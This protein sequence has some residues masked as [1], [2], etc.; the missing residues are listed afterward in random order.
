MEFD[1]EEEVNDEQHK[2]V[3]ELLKMMNKWRRDYGILW[4]E[5]DFNR[6]VFYECD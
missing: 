4:E 3:M 1:A 6:K 2:R 5:I